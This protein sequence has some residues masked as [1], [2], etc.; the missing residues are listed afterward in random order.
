MRKTFLPFAISGLLAAGL[1][2]ACSDEPGIGNGGTGDALVGTS[3]YIVAASVGEANYLLKTDALDAGTISAKNNGLT[4]EDAYFWIFF[5]NKYLYRLMYNQGNAGLSSSY[6]LNSAGKV[7]ERD[8]TYEIKRFTA[9]GIYNNYLITSSTGDMGAAYADA[10]GFLPKGFLFSY[11]DV[12]KETFTTNSE[13]IF[14]ENYLGNGEF[15]TLAGI[16]Q[17]G[18]KLFT[19]PIPMGLSQYGVKAEGGKYVKYPEL[20]KTEAGGSASSAYKAGELQ[21]TQYPDEAWIAIYDDHTY[22][23]PRL[24]RTDKISFACGRYKSQYYQTIWPAANGDIYV[25]SPSYAKTMTAE[26]Q[27]TSL[28][29]GVVRI[30]AGTEEFDNDYYCDIERLAGGNSFLRCWPIAGD[31]FLMLMY[32]RPLTEA[33]FVANRLAIFDAAAQKLTYVEG[34]PSADVVSG[35]GDAPYTENG[36]VYMAITTTDGNQPAIYA[37]DPA[38]AIARKGLTVESEAVGA[39]GKLTVLN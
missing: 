14:S 23:N 36:I 2:T 34:A 22:R 9:T 16:V 10:N 30:K 29:A 4:T 31:Y 8:Y 13:V 20:V 26:V 19:A 28:P 5:K 7:E 17:E 33:A 3:S 38:T 25:F 18:N 1:T 12:E 37:I 6:R 32:D 39:V 27:Q 11:L 21:W 15:V 35:F 24:I